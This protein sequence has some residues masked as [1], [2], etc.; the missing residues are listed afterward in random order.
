MF[1]VAFDTRDMSQAR[2]FRVAPWRKVSLGNDARGTSMYEITNHQAAQI[3]HNLAIELAN[4]LGPQLPVVA[5]RRAKVSVERTPNR[6]QLL[7]LADPA[8]P[9]GPLQLPTT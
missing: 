4:R 8:S 9:A 7:G 2:R 1:G 5:R 6:L 3:E